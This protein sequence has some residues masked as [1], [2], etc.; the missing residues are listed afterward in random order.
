M[1]LMSAQNTWRV[2]KPRGD[3]AKTVNHDGILG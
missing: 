3:M 1:L 2:L